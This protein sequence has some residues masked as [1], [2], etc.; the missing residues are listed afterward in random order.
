MCRR[1]G[2]VSRGGGGLLFSNN[3]EAF[4]SQVGG[5]MRIG[6][7]LADFSWAPSQAALGRDP[8]QSARAADEAGFSS[9]AVMDHYFQISL[10]GPPE[11]PMLEG[12]TLLAFLA[13]QTSRVQLGTL[14]TGVHY[15]HPGLLGKIVTSLD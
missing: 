12:Y 9:I 5:C 14:V 6:L 4:F 7:A 10:I 13:G 2:R 1:V 15:R 3:F 8:G 11:A